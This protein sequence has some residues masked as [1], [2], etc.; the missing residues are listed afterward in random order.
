MEGF[1]FGLIQHFIVVY[2]IE[3][4]IVQAQYVTI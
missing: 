1:H 4:S 3:K 2:F